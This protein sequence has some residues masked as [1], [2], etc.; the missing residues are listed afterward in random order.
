MFLRL[1][2]VLLSSYWKNVHYG[3][4]LLPVADYCTDIKPNQKRSKLLGQDL[5]YLFISSQS[6]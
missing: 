2:L 1:R 6:R 4:N 5:T 3:K